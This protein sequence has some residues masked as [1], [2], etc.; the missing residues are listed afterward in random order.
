VVGGILPTTTSLTSLRCNDGTFSPQEH[1]SPVIAGSTHERNAS[2]G[3]F[4][5]QFQ[6]ESQQPGSRPEKSR[7]LVVGADVVVACLQK[8][9]S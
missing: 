3:M 5:Y 7:E 1:A 6:T 8:R 2:A 9:E 4:F